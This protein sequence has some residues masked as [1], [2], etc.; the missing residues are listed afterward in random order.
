MTVFSGAEICFCIPG[1]L[2]YWL[3][4]SLIVLA[5]GGVMFWYFEKNDQTFWAGLGLS[6]IIFGVFML[7]GPFL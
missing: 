5:C 7:I 3:I 6:I 2:V 4:P 1:W